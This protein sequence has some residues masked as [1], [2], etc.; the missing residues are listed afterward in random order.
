MEFLG[1]GILCGFGTVFYESLLVVNG[2]DGDETGIT[3]IAEVADGF[4]EVAGEEEEEHDE[5]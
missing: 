1:D 3:D 5:E 4:A 2:F